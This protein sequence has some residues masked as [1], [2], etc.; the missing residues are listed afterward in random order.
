MFSS[1]KSLPRALV[2]GILLV[3][4][5]GNAAPVPQ[6]DTF[7]SLEARGANQSGLITPTC[8]V[9]GALALANTQGPINNALFW[10]GTGV[11]LVTVDKVAATFSKKQLRH[12]W[13]DAARTAIQKACVDSNG[14]NYFAPL[15]QAFATLAGGETWVLVG[16]DQFKAKTLPTDDEFL[17]MEVALLKSRPAVTSI[18]MVNAKG[19]K[20]PIP[21]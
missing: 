13:D 12:V 14:P 7:T 19:E 9:A 5:I 15:S 6:S 17:N 8:D 20:K 21:K 11:G 10:S 3:A 18:V 16:D 2:F 1:L 4:Q